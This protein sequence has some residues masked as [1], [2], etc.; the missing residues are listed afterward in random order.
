MP[1]LTPFGRSRIN[2]Q[3]TDKGKPDQSQGRKATGPRFLRDV[4][5]EDSKTAELPTIITGEGES[6]VRTQSKK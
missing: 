4:L 5:S 1:E 3:I 6:Y 2:V